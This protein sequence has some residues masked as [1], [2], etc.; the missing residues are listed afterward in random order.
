M[1]VAQCLSGS[2]PV[3]P[4]TFKVSPHVVFKHSR[5]VQNVLLRHGWS[6]H[7][8]FL[9]GSPLEKS[10]LKSGI[11]HFTVEGFED[12]I[13]PRRRHT[14]IMKRR[15]YD[16]SALHVR[17]NRTAIQLSIVPEISIMYVW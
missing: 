16:I 13:L 4:I 6:Q 5:T 15:K 1:N 3:E 14:E 9:F 11:K 8:E 12:S 2:N 10:Y 7:A 17:W